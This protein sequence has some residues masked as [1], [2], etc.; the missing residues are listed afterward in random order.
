MLIIISRG[1]LAVSLFA[2]PALGAE[3]EVKMLNRGSDG[4]FMVFEPNAVK[5]NVGDT[6][7][8]V[9]ADKGHNA[10][11]IPGL[12]PNGFA[13]AQ[14]KIN[15]EIVVKL[16]QPGAYVFRCTPHF[17]MGMVAVVAVGST[18]SNL[19]IIKQADLPKKARERVDAALATLG[20]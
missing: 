5:A 19:D 9:P 4:Q 3:F 1:M 8:F 16:N 15:E 7:R 18:P 10:G 11:S 12:V 2:G 17:S 13:G 6:I 14:G 20:F